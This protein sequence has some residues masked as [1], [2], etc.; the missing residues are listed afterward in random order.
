MELLVNDALLWELVIKLFL[1]WDLEL[2]V[3][4]FALIVVVL[5]MVVSS[6]TSSASH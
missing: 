5:M 1:S 2:S 3:H 6:M 4:S